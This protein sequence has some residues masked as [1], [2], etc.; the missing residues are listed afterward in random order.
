M[1]WESLPPEGKLRLGPRGQNAVS[2]LD[3]ARAGGGGAGIADRGLDPTSHAAA[4]VA[5]VADRLN[6]RGEFDDQGGS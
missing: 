1:T 6:G 4:P 5:A 3:S 2:G